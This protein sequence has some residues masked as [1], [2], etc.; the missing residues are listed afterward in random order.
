VPQT[1]ANLRLSQQRGEEA[2]ALML[3][4]YRRLR[5]CGEDTTPS[6]QARLTTGK[7]L[8]EAHAFRRKCASK[9]RRRDMAWLSL[10]TFIWTYSR[11]P[12]LVVPGGERAG[13][14]QVGG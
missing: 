1:L 12:I 6:L 4:T 2:A 14:V 10:I 3:E 13:A 9:V 5:A 11:C 8:L 7:L